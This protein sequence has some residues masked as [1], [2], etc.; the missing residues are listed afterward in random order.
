VSWAFVQANWLVLDSGAHPMGAVT[1]TG[2]LWV[3]AC[4][5]YPADT[6]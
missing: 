5:R 4:K 1:M 6:V 3:T 2:W